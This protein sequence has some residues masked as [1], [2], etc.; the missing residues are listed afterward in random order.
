[1]RPAGRRV[2]ATL[3]DCPAAEVAQNA[4]QDVYRWYVFC[5]SSYDNN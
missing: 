4:R 1:M 3:N 2:R 5:Y